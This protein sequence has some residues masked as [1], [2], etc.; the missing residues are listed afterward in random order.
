MPPW[1]DSTILQYQSTAEMPKGKL[2]KFSGKETKGKLYRKELLCALSDLF[3]SNSQLQYRE[4]NMY[5]IQFSDAL[6]GH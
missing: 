3:P 2:G 1:L 5:L 6:V 4:I